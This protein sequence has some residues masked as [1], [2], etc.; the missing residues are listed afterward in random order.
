MQIDNRDRLGVLVACA[1]AQ[2]F[3][4]VQV[5]VRAEPAVLRAGYCQGGAELELD[6]DLSK[7]GKTGDGAK[8]FE[9]TYFGA[10]LNQIGRVSLAR[11]PEAA[12]PTRDVEWMVG[13]PIEQL[14]AEYLA[15]AKVGKQ[16][17]AMG[18]KLLERMAA[19][20]RMAV[21][22]RD[23]GA[24][25]Y[26]PASKRTEIDRDAVKAQL[27]KA[28]IEL[29]MKSTPISASIRVTWAPAS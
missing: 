27:T 14:A 9:E 12:P 11:V 16:A 29:P 17:D 21:D 5:D 24:V 3:E 18:K 15:N 2:G 10:L 22:V 6:V 25:V 26:Q 13:V 8:Y 19:Q 28:G 23:V 1:L 7:F 4:L 20:G